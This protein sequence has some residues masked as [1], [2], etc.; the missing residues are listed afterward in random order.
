MLQPALAVLMQGALPVGGELAGYARHRAVQTMCLLILKLKWQF[1]AALYNKTYR[2][3]YRRYYGTWSPTYVKRTNGQ[4]P[5]AV[6]IFCRC[7]FLLCALCFAPLRFAPCALL[8]TKL[9]FFAIAPSDVEY[10]NCEYPSS[11]KPSE[12]TLKVEV[13]S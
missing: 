5:T 13:S 4:R 11:W 7:H 2:E 9:L 10:L 3:T 8:I 12:R 1:P 6:A